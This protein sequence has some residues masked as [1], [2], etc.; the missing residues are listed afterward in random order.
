M[1]LGIETELEN[2]NQVVF[3]YDGDNPDGSLR[4]IA[5]ICNRD[6]NVCGMMLHPESASDAMLGSTDGLKLFEG[7]DLHL[8]SNRRCI[9]ASL[10]YDEIRCKFLSW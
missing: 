1:G 7:L 9:A 5:S 2:N 8:K 4:N 10:D 6:R 3:R